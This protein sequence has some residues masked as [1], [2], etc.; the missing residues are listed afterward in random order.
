MPVDV[1]FLGSIVNKCTIV[2]DATQ[3]DFDNFLIMIRGMAKQPPKEQL[4]ARIPVDVLRHVDGRV[5]RKV[6][7]RP[8]QVVGGLI[9]F[10]CLGEKAQEAV[11]SAAKRVL[12]GESSW[13]AV[14]D[15][16]G[17]KPGG[18]AS[19]KTLQRMMQAIAQKHETQPRAR[20]Q[21]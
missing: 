2:N 5:L 18:I 7:D 10:E 12:A 21:A 8:V 3:V 20:D 19:E 13:A 11:A 1:G 9:A 17:R 6:W 16:T 4:N 14:L 15:E